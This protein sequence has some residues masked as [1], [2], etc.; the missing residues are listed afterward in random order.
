MFNFLVIEVL[1]E[2]EKI[3]II[4][5]VIEKVLNRFKCYL[6]IEIRII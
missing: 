3:V 4:V 5:L 2:G 6:I 1:I